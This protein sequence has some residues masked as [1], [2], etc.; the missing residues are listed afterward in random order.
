MAA[1]EALTRAIQEHERLLIQLEADATVPPEIRAEGLASI[2]TDCN[3]DTSH[4]HGCLRHTP[5]IED[6]G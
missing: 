3:D 4:S 5:D 2:V 6:E 1:V